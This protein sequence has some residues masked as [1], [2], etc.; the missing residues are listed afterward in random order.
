VCARC[1][2]VD[3]GVEG[4]KALIP[5]PIHNEVLDFQWTQRHLHTKPMA[6]LLSWVARCSTNISITKIEKNKKTC[7]SVLE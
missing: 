2:D 4:T 7:S 3:L 6:L 1:I 5:F